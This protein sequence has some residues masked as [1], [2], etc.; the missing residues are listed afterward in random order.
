[1][2]SE[3]ETDRVRFDRC[4]YSPKHR[5]EGVREMQNKCG[6]CVG[7]G[8]VFLGCKQRCAG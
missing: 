1:M 5:H 3:R 8:C 4:V 7:N 2:E 6:C